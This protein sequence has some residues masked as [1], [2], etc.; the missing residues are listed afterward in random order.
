MLASL[1]QLCLFDAGGCSSNC[2]YY[3][4]HLR[5]E[6]SCAR[7]VVAKRPL[8]AARLEHPRLAGQ[9]GRQRLSASV[10]HGR[11]T[12]SIT[13]A[14]RL[15]SWLVLYTLAGKAQ[16]PM[17]LQP[18]SRLFCLSRLLTYLWAA[19]ASAVG[20]GSPSPSALLLQ[21]GSTSAPEHAS[22]VSVCS[23]L[24]GGWGRKEPRRYIHAHSGEVGQPAGRH[25]VWHRENPP[26][27]NKKKRGYVPIAQVL[28]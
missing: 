9:N 18:R 15:Q 21:H 28:V 19:P 16:R 7:K 24:V 4:N 23:V 5:D 1:L 12:N 20:L 13:Q 8:N 22:T 2:R 10:K 6:Y 11:P 26:L 27:E 14:C 17:K 25:R 3:V